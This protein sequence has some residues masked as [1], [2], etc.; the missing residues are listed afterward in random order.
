MLPA[1]FTPHYIITDN[2]LLVVAIDVSA[3]I[4][5]ICSCTITF[6]S[7]DYFSLGPNRK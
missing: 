6:I 3:G 7:E 5:N 1:T 2:G 4:L